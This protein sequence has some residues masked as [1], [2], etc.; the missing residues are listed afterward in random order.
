MKGRRDATRGWRR[1]PGAGFFHSL[2]PKRAQAAA[3]LALLGLGACELRQLPRPPAA[4]SRADSLAAVENIRSMLQA[5]AQDW[6]AGNLDGFLDDYWRSSELTFLGAGG[7]TRGW[8]A[9]R[10]K[11]LRSYFAPD[12]TRPYLRFDQVEVR[13]L[14]TDHALA[15][16][17]YLLANSPF[18]SEA[19]QE[20]ISG[21]GYFSL[22]LRRMAGQWR[23]VH[24][25]TTA[26][27][28]GSHPGG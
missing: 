14:G 10:E 19:D 1:L 9:V 12:V 6:N 18:A 22:V 2:C 23:I 4:G 28:L 15:T 7:L 25:H 8:E 13:L 20:G 26:A 21:R 11:Y 17:R 3:A 16:G 27:P 5:S 24:D